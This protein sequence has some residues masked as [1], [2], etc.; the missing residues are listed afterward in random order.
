M[1]FE[2]E[3]LIF[4][5]LKKWKS[6]ESASRIQSP[7]QERKFCKHLFCVVCSPTTLK[8]S[9]HRCLARGMTKPSAHLRCVALEK[10]STVWEN[11]RCM[12]RDSMSHVLCQAL[13]EC[14]Q[15]RNLQREGLSLCQWL[16]L[17]LVTLIASLQASLPVEPRV[18]YG[19]RGPSA[20]RAVAQ[21]YRLYIIKLKS[22]DDDTRVSPAFKF[23][24]ICRG[25]LIS[26]NRNGQIA[27]MPSCLCRHFRLFLHGAD[28]HRNREIPIS[29]R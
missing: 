7:E 12:S 24:R 5:Q 16:L 15:Y 2:N 13:V 29:D 14:G 25:A 19:G 18:G 4:L 17:L 10:A 9:D 26:A 3:F 23:T 27:L 6:N 21:L 28:L 8:C 20:R 1:L 22:G 11:D